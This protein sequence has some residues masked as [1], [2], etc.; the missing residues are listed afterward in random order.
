MIGQISFTYMK[1][2]MLADLS[3]DMTWVCEDELVEKVLNTFFGAESPYS[4]GDGEEGAFRLATAAEFFHGK[5]SI[6]QKPRVYPPGV[7]F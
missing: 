7:L 6:K 2:P 5:V 3:D 4:P 1:R